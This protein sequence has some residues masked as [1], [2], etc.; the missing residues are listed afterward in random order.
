MDK[1]TFDNV[2][3]D[4]PVNGIESQYHYWCEVRRNMLKAASVDSPIT[5]Y[6]LVQALVHVL[7]IQGLSAVEQLEKMFPGFSDRLKQYKA[8]QIQLIQ[9]LHLLHKEV[10]KQVIP[11][12]DY[13]N[14]L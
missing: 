10:S 14:H 11:F 3:Y 13:L 7:S 6:H 5:D 12:R 2:I 4:L 1:R 8:L 9:E